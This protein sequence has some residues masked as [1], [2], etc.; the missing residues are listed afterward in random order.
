MKSQILRSNMLEVESA[1]KIFFRCHTWYEPMICL[2]W[3]SLYTIYIHLHVYIRVH[4]T[5]YVVHTSMECD[6]NAWCLLA[7][8]WLRKKTTANMLWPCCTRRWRFWRPWLLFKALTMVCNG[9]I[10]T[11]E[12]R[13][14]EKIPQKH[15]TASVSDTSRC[16]HCGGV[17]EIW[18]CDFCLLEMYW[19]IWKRFGSG[20]LYLQ[21]PEVSNEFCKLYLHAFNGAWCNKM[22][23]CD[24]PVVF[25]MGAF[26]RAPYITTIYRDIGLMWSNQHLIL[27]KLE[28]VKGQFLFHVLCSTRCFVSIKGFVTTMFNELIQFAPL[29]HWGLNGSSGR[30][31]DWRVPRRMLPWGRQAN[32]VV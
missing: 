3:Y 14:L 22:T 12:M 6:S 4:I 9:C 8:R 19:M 31:W 32:S 30:M 23:W 11:K 2:F 18:G 25:N 16:G 21:D 27:T 15:P 7:S 29:Q 5:T 28:P 1:W 17:K 13:L 26:T 20:Y 24:K 10:W